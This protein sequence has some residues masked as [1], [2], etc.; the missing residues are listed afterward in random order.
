MGYYNNPVET[1]QEYGFIEVVAVG[2]LEEPSYSFYDFAVLRKEDGYYLSTD[3]G[4]SCPTPWESHTADDFTGPLT[5]EQVHEEVRS[6]WQN[7]NP[8][9]PEQ[10]I[11][12]ALALVV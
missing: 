12:D 5:A 10:E 1:P 7:A 2:E 4:C 11:T 3:S 8:P 9:V 6:L